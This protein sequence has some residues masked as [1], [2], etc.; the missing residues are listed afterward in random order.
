MFVLVFNNTEVTITDDPINNAANR[1][2]RNSHTE[3]FLPWVNI[4]NYNLLPDGR[5]FYDQPINDIIKQYNEIRKITT[6]QGDDYTTD[7]CY[8]I[9]ILKTI[10]I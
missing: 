4:T 5:N 2:E 6:G 8:I 9:S 7:V 10:T 1:V 3:Y